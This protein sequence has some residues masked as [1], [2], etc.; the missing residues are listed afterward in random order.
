MFI[1][2]RPNAKAKVFLASL[3]QQGCMR[4]AGVWVKL[5][6]EAEWR[7]IVEARQST[8]LH[9]RSI[10]QSNFSLPAYPAPSH[11]IWKVIQHITRRL[12]KTRRHTS[13]RKGTENS[14]WNLSLAHRCYSDLYYVILLSPAISNSQQSHC[15]H[16]G[17]PPPPPSFSCF[18]Q[19]AQCCRERPR[20]SHCRLWFFINTL[21]L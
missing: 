19:S 2:L 8:V 17:S 6:R 21:Q 18:A 7:E 12:E 10:Y 15:L 5:R 3:R 4:W 16:Q 9:A 13:W 14:C 11:E 1:L 20:L